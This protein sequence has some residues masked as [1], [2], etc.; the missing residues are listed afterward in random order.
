MQLSLL[1]DD[2]P[3]FFLDL[4][5]QVV[6]DSRRKR[7]RLKTIDHQRVPGN[8]AVR[9]PRRFF[10]HFPT[11]TIYKVDAR[12]IQSPGKQPYFVAINQRTMQPALEF[13][14]H[15]RSIQKDEDLSVKITRKRKT[16]IHK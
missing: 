15:N 7:P 4:Y 6:F 16:N 11:G 8:I 13:F 1:P 5:A 12:L 2:E 3:R 14:D 9:C 10:Q